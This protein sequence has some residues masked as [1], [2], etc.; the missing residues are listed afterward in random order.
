MRMPG[1]LKTIEGVYKKLVIHDYSTLSPAP[2][3]PTP[4]PIN[5]RWKIQNDT[6]NN[7]SS[8]GFRFKLNFQTKCH[9]E[10]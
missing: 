5:L 10:T 1:L 2:P 8:G 6:Q 7:M 4:T 3:P 9:L